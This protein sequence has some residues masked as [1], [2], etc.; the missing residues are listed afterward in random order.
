MSYRIT[1]QRP[2]DMIYPILAKYQ[3][4]SLPNEL[5]FEQTIEDVDQ[6]MRP[7]V[8]LNTDFYEDIASE[9][10]TDVSEQRTVADIE[11]NHSKMKH[12]KLKF[13]IN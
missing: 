1:A 5:R 11:M 3:S 4:S 2:I 6:A 9:T 12:F 7:Y 13:I 10:V 8:Q